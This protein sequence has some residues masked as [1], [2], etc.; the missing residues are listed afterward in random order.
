[1]KIDWFP[2]FSHI[3]VVTRYIH[4]DCFVRELVYAKV[5]QIMVIEMSFW[6]LKSVIVWGVSAIYIWNKQGK[7]MLNFEGIAFQTLFSSK[8]FLVLY[9]FVQ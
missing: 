8:H 5:M 6:K 1:M 9:K 3:L 2:H 4:V 7:K